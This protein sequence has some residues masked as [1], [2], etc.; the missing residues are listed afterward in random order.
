[1]VYLILYLCG[2]LNIKTSQISNSTSR[3]A[4][5]L[6]SLAA[7]QVTVD[8]LQKLTNL[9]TEHGAL[10]IKRVVN[11][12]TDTVELLVWR[13]ITILDPEVMPVDMDALQAQFTKEFDE[14]KKVYLPRISLFDVKR[15]DN[16]RKWKVG[17]VLSG[18]IHYTDQ[19]RCYLIIAG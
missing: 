6:V 4:T 14:T 13:L 3:E 8:Q 19:H 1:M 18:D 15:D 2:M 7:N 16:S 9:Q 17:D 11:T 5:L 10:R 12:E